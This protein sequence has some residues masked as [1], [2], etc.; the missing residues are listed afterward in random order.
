MFPLPNIVSWMAK[1]KGKE[2]GQ[3]GKERGGN[4]RNGKGGVIGIN[5]TIKEPPRDMPKQ[6]ANAR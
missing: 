4:A 2:G 5:K 1:K 3:L 6:Q